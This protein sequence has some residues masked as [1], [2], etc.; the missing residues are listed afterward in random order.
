MFILLPEIPS[1]VSNSLRTCC[2]LKYLTGGWEADGWTG[3]KREVDG[4][5]GGGWADGWMPRRREKDR[6]MSGPTLNSE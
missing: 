5:M 4:L 3:A 1:Q 2:E 6:W